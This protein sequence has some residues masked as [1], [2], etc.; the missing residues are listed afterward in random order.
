MEKQLKQNVIKHCKQS[1]K[2]ENS[3]FFVCAKILNSIFG[4]KN[5]G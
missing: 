1:Q 2:R 5:N 4:S 3:R